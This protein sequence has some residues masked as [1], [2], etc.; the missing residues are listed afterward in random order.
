MKLTIILHFSFLFDMLVAYNTSVL[1]QFSAHINDAER[2]NLSYAKSLDRFLFDA[3]S[4]S[5]LE[6][7]AFLFAPDIR[8]RLLLFSILRLNRVLRMYRMVCIFKEKE[9]DIRRK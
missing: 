3:I 5:P 9:H 7:I 8:N 1:D 6:G 4:N 2:V